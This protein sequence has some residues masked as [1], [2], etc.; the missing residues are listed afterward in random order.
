[1]VVPARLAPHA[2]FADEREPASNARPRRRRRRRRSGRNAPRKRTRT[3]RLVFVLLLRRERVRGER[4]GQTTFPGGSFAS[5]KRL[6]NRSSRG[7]RF[8]T[9]FRARLVRVPGVPAPLPAFPGAILAADPTH[10]TRRR[11]PDRT[12]ARTPLTGRRRRLERRVCLAFRL[13]FGFRRRPRLRALLRFRRRPRLRALLRPALILRLFFFR[14]ALH[15]H[16]SQIVP[17]S[18]RCR[19]ERVEIV[20]IVVVLREGARESPRLLSLSRHLRARHRGDGRAAKIGGLGVVREIHEKPVQRVVLRGALTRRRPR[21]REHDR[22]AVDT[23]RRR[24]GEKRRSGE[25]RLGLGLGT[26]KRLRLRLG[27]RA[28]RAHG[29]RRVVRRASDAEELLGTRGDRPE[30]IDPT[31]RRR[32]VVFERRGGEGTRRGGEGITGDGRPN[33]GPRSDSSVPKVAERRRGFLPV[34]HFRFPGGP[35]SRFLPASR[36]RF[37]DAVLPALLAED[38]R[39]GESGRDARGAF[40]VRRL[41]H[42]SSGVASVSR[43]RADRLRGCSRSCGGRRGARRGAT[44]RRRA[45]LLLLPHRHQ[46]LH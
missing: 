28:E 29:E 1:M 32:G 9:A 18:L 19:G 39:Q 24:P 21:L 3:R 5:E 41:L 46:R 15:L 25:S 14:R 26:R 8:A 45:R 11:R 27:R 38:I 35:V 37:P 33:P 31:R 30:G 36:A 20:G 13:G 12:R 2:P 7:V 16:L 40:S 4:L 10:L 34:F 42:P 43:T 23:L 44:L 6:A 22:V 17:L